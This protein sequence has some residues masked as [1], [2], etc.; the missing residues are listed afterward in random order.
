MRLWHQVWVIT[1]DKQETAINIAISCRLIHRPDDLLIC[2]AHTYDEA[3]VRLRE[4]LDTQAA[5]L[6]PGGHPHPLPV[7]QGAN[8]A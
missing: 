1:G 6:A 8:P 2:N 5:R 3:A 4:L 7:V